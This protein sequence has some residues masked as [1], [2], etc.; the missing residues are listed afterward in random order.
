MCRLLSPPPNQTCPCAWFCFNTIDQPIK[1]QQPPVHHQSN[2][3][4]LH[5]EYTKRSRKKEEKRTM[6]Y[7]SVFSLTSTE[8]IDFVVCSVWLHHQQQQPTERRSLKEDDDALQIDIA[9]SSC[10]MTYV[11]VFMLL[12]LLARLNQEQHNTYRQR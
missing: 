8:W 3:Q 2:E 7:Q 6:R 11:L 10:T 12:S 4:T 5:S 9:M 1:Q